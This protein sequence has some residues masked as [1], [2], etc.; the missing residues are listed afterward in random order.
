MKK[1]QY[2]YSDSEAGEQDVVFE[3]LS[4]I[5]KYIEDFDKVG[6]SDGIIY[7]N[8]VPILS[9]SNREYGLSWGTV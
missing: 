1:L 4:E 5:V 9:Y 2:T 7:Q 8:D 3:T 6:E